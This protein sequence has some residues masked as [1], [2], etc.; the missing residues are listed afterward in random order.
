MLKIKSI[1]FDFDGVIVESVDIKSRAFAHLFKDHP[2]QVEQIVEYHR[3]HGG[4]SR[5]EKFE[6]I[7]RE[8][9]HKEL[10][11]EEKAGLGKRF[12]EYVY[13][14][15]VKCPFVPGAK[16]FL[17]KYYKSFKFFIVSGTPQEE[18]R[19]IIKDRGLQKY[20][21]E[22]YGAPAKKAELNLGILRNYLLNADETLFIGDSM[23]DWEGAHKSGIK[24]MGRIGREDPFAGSKVEGT[25]RD[26]FDL[27]QVLKDKN[28][29]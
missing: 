7:Y 24:F 22:V 17:D 20:F 19:S 27:E 11:A 21:I 25:F 15:V 29:V 4:L 13:Q 18:I 16:E 5:F 28:Y 26:L 3:R 10:T 6:T 9:L 8:I 23:D 14:E 1:I 2:D 12:A